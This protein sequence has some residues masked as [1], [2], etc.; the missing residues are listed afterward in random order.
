M[1]GKIATGTTS[2]F[3]GTDA[4][5]E[6]KRQDLKNSNTVME[7]L[8]NRPNITVDTTSP[9]EYSPTKIAGGSQTSQELHNLLRAYFKIEKIEQD[10]DGITDEFEKSIHEAL[11]KS[12]NCMLPCFNVSCE[13]EI[14]ADGTFTV[15]DIGGSTL[16]VSVVRFSGNKGVETL[17]NQSWTINE[18]MKSF[19]EKFFHWVVTN[20]KTVVDKD[21]M[22][23][24]KDA[25]GFI[26]L[27]ITWSFPI[28]QNETADRGIISDLGKG[29]SIC[30]NFR[31]KDLKD[32][33]ESCFAQYDVAIKVFAIINDSVSVLVAGSY[34]NGA[35]IGLV[36]GTGINSCFLVEPD[37]LGD[38][39]KSTFK[40]IPTNQQILINSEA[41]FLGYHLHRYVTSA[42]QSMKRFWMDADQTGFVPPHLT[43]ENGVHQP[44][45]WLTSGRYIPETVRQTLVQ[46][47]ADD[48]LAGAELFQSSKSSEY[49]LTAQLLSTLYQ[50]EDLS[51][52]KTRLEHLIRV[53][54]IRDEHLAM[55][56]ATT[57]I[58][59]YRASLIM[60][61]YIIALVKVAN[62]TQLESLEISVV[63]SM[64]QYFP[65]YKQTV[66]ELLELE[67]KKRQLP[68]I[69]FDFI[70][71]SSIHGA[72]IA[73]FVNMYKMSPSI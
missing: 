16:R 20:F 39:K 9:L 42:D 29:F 40:Q 21:L 55:L 48:E 4:V 67:T 62:F 38:L 30:E 73:S 51:Q 58:V 37:L 46:M 8:Q 60:A 1:I 72:G 22:G 52:F 56:K 7:Q 57:E 47:L 53:E 70:K 32:I 11:E 64:L 23:I 2:A 19:D 44:L 3:S 35:K 5:A 49:S 26:K 31:G 54:N 34:F 59:V 27:G 65:R 28:I 17:A 14:T 61:S 25:S 68:T 43:S 66:L 63:G 6:T 41:S 33:F 36:Q 10:L 15:I 24:T 45:E 71:D 12:N 69:S 50:C 18:D 13:R